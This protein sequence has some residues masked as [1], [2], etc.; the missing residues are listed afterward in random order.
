MLFCWFD[1]VGVCFRENRHTVL[2]TNHPQRVAARC[3]SVGHAQGGE[4]GVVRL[5]PSVDDRA[6]A[7]LLVV[8]PAAA[9]HVLLITGRVE[10]LDGQPSAAS[11]E[12]DVLLTLYLM[13]AALSAMSSSAFLAS[14][15]C[16]W[17]GVSLVS[18]SMSLR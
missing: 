12:L 5:F 4:D 1:W 13:E 10:L 14:L 7:R 11:V 18:A 8:R 9:L 3:V 16:R 2:N 17:A 15:A 6:G